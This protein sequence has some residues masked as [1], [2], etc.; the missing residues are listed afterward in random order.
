[1][2]RISLSYPHFFPLSLGIKF[3]ETN[4]DLSIFF[5][6]VLECKI[7]ISKN[8]DKKKLIAITWGLSHRTNTINLIGGNKKVSHVRM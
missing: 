5:F 7:S 6:P 2:L 4:L 3:T 1:M 8:N